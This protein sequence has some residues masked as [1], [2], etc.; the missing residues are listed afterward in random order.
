[1]SVG[2]RSQLPLWNGNPDQGED[3]ARSSRHGGEQDHP[4][5]C[6]QRGISDRQVAI[7]QEVGDV[8]LDAL[9][10]YCRVCELSHRK[11]P[12]GRQRAEA[13]DAELWERDPKKR[14]VGPSAKCARSLLELGT[15]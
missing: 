9:P 8:V 2:A 14:P 7:L 5:R 3:E 10:E 4:D 15:Q 11:G 12:A 6:T 13:R 1:M